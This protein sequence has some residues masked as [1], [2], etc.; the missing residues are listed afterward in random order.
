MKEKEIIALKSNEII[1]EYMSEKDIICI[2]DI[3]NTIVN[4]TE[5]F[6]FVTKFLVYR[7]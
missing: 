3:V 7:L 5:N 6:D 4:A 1:E 2:E